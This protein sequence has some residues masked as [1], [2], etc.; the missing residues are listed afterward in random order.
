MPY[1]VDLA[2]LRWCALRN[3]DTGMDVALYIHALPVASRQLWTRGERLSTC[4][5]QNNSPSTLWGFT[6]LRLTQHVFLFVFVFVFVGL[7]YDRLCHIGNLCCIGSLHSV[8]SLCH[9]GNLCCIGSLHCVDSLCHI[10][11]L[12]CIGSL[13]SVD[14]LCHIGNL[15]FINGQRR[16]RNMHCVDRIP[17][18]INGWEFQ[19]SSKYMANLTLLLMPL[20]QKIWINFYCIWVER[21]VNPWKLLEQAVPSSR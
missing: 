21:C 10:G 18:T 8:D 9:I 16:I 19:P 4:D 6:L 13:H 11:N 20:K 3:E 2:F 17:I 14:S 15:H 12:R 7:C 1:A 5:L